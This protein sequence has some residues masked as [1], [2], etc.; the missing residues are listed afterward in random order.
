M[1]I[2]RF[3]LLAVCSSALAVA[4]AGVALAKGGFHGEPLDLDT[5]LSHMTEQLG[6][7]GQ[8]Q[9][10]IRLVMLEQQAKLVALR[11]QIDREGHGPE[12]KEAVREAFMETSRSFASGAGSTA[13]T[14]AAAAVVAVAARETARTGASDSRPDLPRRA[15]GDAAGRRP[16]NASGR[17]AAARGQIE[18][19]VGG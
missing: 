4:V 18:R 9:E 11:E 13:V 15:S 17:F 5:R 1:R 16:A 2:T 14:H 10:D 8:Q 12:L 7:S 3:S 6:L 19:G